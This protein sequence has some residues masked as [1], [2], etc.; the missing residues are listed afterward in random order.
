M[1]VYMYV[2]KRKR[3]QKLFCAH[4]N[5]RD[6]SV[7]LSCLFEIVEPEKVTKGCAISLDFRG[8]TLYHRSVSSDLR[9]SGKEYEIIY[10][11]LETDTNCV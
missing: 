5:K 7:G 6:R 9:F 3:D 11:T 1:K 10:R 4:G 8:K 2:I